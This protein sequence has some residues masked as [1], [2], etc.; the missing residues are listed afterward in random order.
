MRTAFA[1]FV[2]L[3]VLPCGPAYAQSAADIAGSNQKFW[4]AGVSTSPMIGLG[5]DDF[6]VHRSDFIRIPEPVEG[7]RF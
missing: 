2:M 3:A 5:R 6:S 1:P 7:T 4:S